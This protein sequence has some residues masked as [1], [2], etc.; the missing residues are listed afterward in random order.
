MFLEP[1]VSESLSRRAKQKVVC[2]AGRQHLNQKEAKPK[3]EEHSFYVFLSGKPTLQ[4]A[5]VEEIAK[6]ELHR[7]LG[8]NPKELKLI[9]VKLSSG[10][11]PACQ[12]P[13]QQTRDET[14][15]RLCHCQWV[16]SLGQFY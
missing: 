11:I 16:I 10:L 14:L 4:A 3:I 15:Q 7:F 12:E 2:I 8:N 13:T 5:Q 6:H 1:E 9:Q